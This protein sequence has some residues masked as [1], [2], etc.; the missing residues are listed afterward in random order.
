MTSRTRRVERPRPLTFA[1]YRHTAI[2]VAAAGAMLMLPL[3]APAATDIEL[4]WIGVAFILG[5]LAG[6]GGGWTGLLLLVSG[7]VLGIGIDLATRHPAAGDAAAALGDDAVLHLA[8][9]GA[10]IIGYLLTMAAR[11]VLRGRREHA[12]S[13]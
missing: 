5:A 10:A 4:I 9:V 13:E 7:L 2:F 11:Q 8:V 6:V 12:L 3:V 1:A